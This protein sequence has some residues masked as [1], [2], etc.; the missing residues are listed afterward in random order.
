L[1]GWHLLGLRLWRLNR[2]GLR[3]A[4]WLF[5]WKFQRLHDDGSQWLTNLHVFA[6][7]DASSRLPAEGRITEEH[8]LHHAADMCLSAPFPSP[9]SLPMQPVL[10]LNQ[11]NGLPVAAVEQDSF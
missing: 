11:L 2:L 10:A 6:P 9:N 5:H 3:F 1:F 8:H 7:F 4:G